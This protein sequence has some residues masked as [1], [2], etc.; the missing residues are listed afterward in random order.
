[1]SRSCSVKLVFTLLSANVIYRIFYHCKKKVFTQ[2][3]TTDI[4]NMIH[5]SE[6]GYP[7]MDPSVNV[8]V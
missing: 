4:S 8:P 2:L 7:N 1:M 5:A 3:I 6:R